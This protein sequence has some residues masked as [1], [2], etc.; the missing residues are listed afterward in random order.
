MRET[1]DFWGEDG[2]EDSDLALPAMT[3]VVFQLL[4]V[5][6][7]S[8]SSQ[9][10]MLALFNFEPALTKGPTRAEPG[11]VLSVSYTHLTLPTN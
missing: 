2:A 6:M 5:F 7:L 10:A 3:D 11:R 8:V 1:A 4:F 9:G